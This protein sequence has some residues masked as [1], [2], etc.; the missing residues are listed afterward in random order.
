[1]SS[2][3]PADF[4][5][6]HRVILEY[7]DDDAPRFALVDWYLKHGHKTRADS[8]YRAV[9][10]REFVRGPLSSLFHGRAIFRRGFAEAVIL[11]LD[12]FISHDAEIFGNHPI[13]RVEFADLDPV[14]D[15]LG[16]GTWGWITGFVSP[17]DVDD[18]VFIDNDHAALPDPFADIIEGPDATGPV[19]TGKNYS[20][21][22]GAIEALSR[23]AVEIGR[24]AAG[25]GL[26]RRRSVGSFASTRTLIASSS[27]AGTQA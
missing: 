12:T 3:M 21:K 15:I 14:A 8:L 2:I 20:T 11:D 23:A 26:G 13:T 24:K 19:F 1:M 18:L 16:L 7:P 17:D 4:F 27:L 25:L 5:A 22:E 10:N 9:V 6:L